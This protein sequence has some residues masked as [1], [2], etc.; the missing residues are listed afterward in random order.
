MLPQTPGPIDATSR[1]PRPGSPSP[2]TPAAPILSEPDAKAA[3]CCAE[4]I[5][6]VCANFL[7]GP[8]PP[9]TE[10]ALEPAVLAAQSAALARGRAGLALLLSQLDRALPGRGYGDAASQF[11][12]RA[13]QAVAEVPMSAALFGG[14]TGIAWVSQ[15]LSRFAEEA[16]ALAPV[17]QLL[18]AHV[19]RGVWQA[20]WDL[21]SGLVGIGLYALHRRPRAAARQLLAGVVDRLSELAE[22][23]DGGVAW[24]TPAAFL[25]ADQRRAAPDGYYNLGV[26]HGVAGIIGLLGHI[27]ATGEPCADRAR[28]L[29]AGAVRWLLAQPRPHGSAQ[30]FGSWITTQGEMRACRMGWCYG[31]P[32]VAVALLGAARR[33]GE[34]SWEQAA[35]DIASRSLQVPSAETGVVDA[36]LCHGTAGLLHLYGVLYRSTGLEPFRA[37]AGDW[38]R[39]TFALRRDHS[40]GV[41]G[42]VS[43]EP[44]DLTC[45]GF[46]CGAAGVGLA[47][48]AAATG[49]G[50]GWEEL[51][52][53]SVPSSLAAQSPAGS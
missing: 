9:H 14:I 7:D 11:L 3:S 21:L 31:D 45:P 1:S 53:M 29:L 49:D 17:D 18:V 26:A 50:S 28:P 2:S 46:L 42:F 30:R 23:R 33:A 51:L 36:P 48:L 12:D 25:P 44:G 39:S 16:D 32:G 8:L 10:Q 5:A 40:T 52:L 47:L 13:S 22:P 15:T 43:K 24:H 19:E 34:A 37:A 6:R 20:R 38:A 27:L 41:A 35:L 4:E